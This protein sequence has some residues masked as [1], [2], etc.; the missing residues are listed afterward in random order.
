M[1]IRDGRPG[2]PLIVI[3]MDQVCELRNIHMSWIQIAALFGVSR[4]T[5][6]R[7]CKEVGYVE[8][9][10]LRRNVSD[11]E[12]YQIVQEIKEKLPDIGERIA[13]GH[14]RACGISVSR[15]RVRKTIHDLDPLTSLRWNPK[16][17]RQTYSVPG[18]NSLWHIGKSFIFSAICM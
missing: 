6:Y 3:D 13:L 16:I 9:E 11:N 10:S 7:R 2:R 15:E 14:I 17:S 4:T 5:L 1:L 8:D 12:L 18:P